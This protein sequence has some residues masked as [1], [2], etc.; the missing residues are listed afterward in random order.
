MSTVASASSRTDSVS[1][2]PT[3]VTGSP[4]SRSSDSAKPDRDSDAPTEATALTAHS[5]EDPGPSPRWAR[6]RPSS[7]SVARLWKGCSSWRTISSPTRAVERQWTLRR[8]SPCRY[9]LVAA[10]SLPL[11]AIEREAVSPPPAQ[12]P[13]SRTGGSALTTG[14]TTRSS[15][16]AKDRVSSHSPNGSVSRTDSGPTR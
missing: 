15:E 2:S 7:S 8:S 11:V 12:S 9:S 4:V 1:G 6:A 10:S 13:P 3:G 16:V 5:N 14:V